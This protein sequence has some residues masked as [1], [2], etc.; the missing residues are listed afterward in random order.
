MNTFSL[1][2]HAERI[3]AGLTPAVQKRVF[4]KVDRMRYRF[5]MSLFGM[6]LDKRKFAADFG[7]PI[8]LG[9][10]VEM[11]FMRSV[12]AFSIDNADEVILTAKGRYLLV[13]MMREFFVGVNNLRDQA[14]S[15]LSTRERELLFGDGE[16][17]AGSD[18][19]APIDTDSATLPA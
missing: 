9:L 14:R 2:L 6:R 7:I 1:A 4:T 10:A 12:G 15:A 5:L 8:D 3:E 17:G 16:C 13:A 18:D 19:V 11:A